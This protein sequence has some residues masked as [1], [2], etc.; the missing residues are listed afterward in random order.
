MVSQV[1]PVCQAKG[2]TTNRAI[3]VVSVCVSRS[4]DC[5][6]GILANSVCWWN[7]SL[8]TS[9]LMELAVVGPIPHFSCVCVCML[10]CMGVNMS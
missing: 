4:G 9:Q 10:D 1:R 6:T 7:H 8:G 2:L 5:M 3:V